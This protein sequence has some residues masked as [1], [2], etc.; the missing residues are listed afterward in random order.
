MFVTC[1]HDPVGTDR[2]EIDLD[3]GKIV[4]ENSKKATILR[5][6]KTE[7]EMNATMTMHQVSRL[8]MGGGAD[9]MYDTETFENTDGWGTQH[10]QVMTNFAAHILDGTPLLAPG[11]DGICGVQLAN[12]VLLS[13]WLG[14]D[15]DV[16]VGEDVYVQELN[17]RIAE[18]GKFPTR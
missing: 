16:P 2:L 6:K 8:V 4:V 3:N 5:F 15:V 13:G 14:K 12:A 10:C 9:Q 1:T 18:E 11:S 7:D 17:K